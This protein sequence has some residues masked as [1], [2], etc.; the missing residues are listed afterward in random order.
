MGK[1]VRTPKDN[2][3]DTAR[4]IPLHFEREWFGK[5][6]EETKFGKL[7]GPICT[8]N[9]RSE[10]TARGAYL[11]VRPVLRYSMMPNNISN[12]TVIRAEKR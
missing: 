9:V 1:K 11:Y 7:S 4:S 12:M 2:I 8:Q 5:I 6:S 10:I 3:E